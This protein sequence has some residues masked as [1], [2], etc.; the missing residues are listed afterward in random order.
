MGGDW[1]DLGGTLS[2]DAIEPVAFQPLA[3]ISDPAEQAWAAEW[4]AAI[5]AREGVS[6]TPEAKDHLWSALTSLVSAPTAE[7]TLTGLSV[8]LQSGALKRALQPGRLDQDVNL[9]GRGCPAFGVADDP[10]NRIAGGDRAGADQLLALLQRDVGHLAGT[11]RW[12][13]FSQSPS[14]TCLLNA[15]TLSR[16]PEHCKQRRD[17]AGKCHNGAPA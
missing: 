5:I 15:T 13:I 1:H 8:L 7:R 10:A 2:N 14:G 6:V 16:R 3:A 4:V 12:E 11:S 17:L 9:L